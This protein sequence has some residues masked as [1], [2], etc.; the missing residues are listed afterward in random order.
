MKFHLIGN[1]TVLNYAI[2]LNSL[3]LK[4]V[5]AEDM[6]AMSQNAVVLTIE[7]TF[8]PPNITQ[9]AFSFDAFI[10][11]YIGTAS[12]DNDLKSEVT[13]VFHSVVLFADNL[14]DKRVRSARENEVMLFA[15]QSLELVKLFR[16]RFVV[17]SCQLRSF[18][19][20]SIKSSFSDQNLFRWAFYAKFP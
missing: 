2:G 13:N 7:W 4:I 8:W 1:I 9:I 14:A 10:L 3:P 15:E 19:K 12:P 11:R 6:F 18:H 16:N 17:A 20:H 5:V